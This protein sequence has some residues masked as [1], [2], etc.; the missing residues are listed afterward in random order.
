MLTN[1]FDSVIPQL[2]KSGTTSAKVHPKVS[3]GRIRPH[4]FIVIQCAR[5]R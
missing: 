3:I 5:D 1:L 2:R 4:H